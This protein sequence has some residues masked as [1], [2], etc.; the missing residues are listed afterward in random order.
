MVHLANN[1][2]VR[3]SGLTRQR[4]QVRPAMG[5][6]DRNQTLCSNSAV[7][8]AACCHRSPARKRHAEE[9]RTTLAER[10]ERLQKLGRLDPKTVAQLVN[11]FV[12][13]FQGRRLIHELRIS[14]WQ[15]S[16]KQPTQ[17]RMVKKAEKRW[18]LRRF[19]RSEVRSIDCSGSNSTRQAGARSAVKISAKRNVSPAATAA[20]RPNPYFYA[21]SGRQVLRAG[22][23]P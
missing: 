9:R 1:G 7:S 18:R 2:S 16:V 8:A 4:R 23:S 5:D 21:S 17:F 13:G 6:K 15:K 19:A 11:N 12:Y 20:D 22:R 3:R 10:A 14:G